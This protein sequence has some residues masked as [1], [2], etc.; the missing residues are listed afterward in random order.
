MWQGFVLC[1][2]GDLA[3]AESALRTALEGYAQWGFAERARVYAAAFQADVLLERGDL[4]GARAALD[5]AEDPGDRSDGARYWLNSRMELLVAEGRAEEAISAADDFARRFAHYRNPAYARWRTCQAQALDRLGRTDES[6][7]LAEEELEL[8][9]AWGAPGAV[10]TTLRILGRLRRR[11]GLEELRQ[12]V[13]VLDGSAAR[14]ELAKALATYGGALRRAGKPGEAR[15]PLRRA[16]ELAAVCDAPGLVDQMRSELHASGARPRRNALSGP[17]A[18]TPSERRVADLAAGGATNRD[19]AQALFVTPKTV[20]IHLSNA[21][22]K[23]GIRSRRELAR[24]LRA[25]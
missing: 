24:A 17:E 19:I 7:A 13:E 6:I 1:R 11:A 18:L 23:L 4:A 22:R 9:R 21:Y 8:A 10:G 16:L 14:L 12:A 2:R 5:Q 15:E 25:S 3:G 20:E